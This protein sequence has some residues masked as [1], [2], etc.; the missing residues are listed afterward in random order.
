MIGNIHPLTTLQPGGDD[1]SG[2]Q[3]ALQWHDLAIPDQ[4][5]GS[6]GRNTF[7]GIR[8]AK[9]EGKTYWQSWADI[10][11]CE[12]FDQRI[13]ST[14]YDVVFEADH[15]E[16]DPMDYHEFPVRDFTTAALAERIAS[17]AV[18]RSH[19]RGGQASPEDMVKITI[20]LCRTRDMM[21]REWI[22]EQERLRRQREYDAECIDLARRVQR[23]M[24]LIE[25]L[26]EQDG[27]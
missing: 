7:S 12:D 21:V 24:L 22:K 14:V 9:R 26:A 1:G 13:Y 8:E 19:M 27:A 3:K 16:F 23:G 5:S 4:W 18:A 15:V 2:W 17:A 6:I 10:I 20:N 25:E 11:N